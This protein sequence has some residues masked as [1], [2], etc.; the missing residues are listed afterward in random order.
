M[1]AQGGHGQRREVR[2]LLWGD[3]L[4]LRPGVQQGARAAQG[5]GSSADHDGA[6]AAKIK[7][8]WEE[9]HVAQHSAPRTGQPSPTDR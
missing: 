6:H 5:H 9:T 4:H 7:E 2:V 8:S 1:A 3:D